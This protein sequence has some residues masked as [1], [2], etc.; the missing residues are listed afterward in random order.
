MKQSRQTLRRA[1]LKIKEKMVVQTE[2]KMI[3][4]AFLLAGDAVLV[5]DRR[6]AK[7]LLHRL[8]VTEYRVT[9]K[10]RKSKELIKCRSD[11]LWNRLFIVMAIMCG[12]NVYFNVNCVV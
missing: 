10:A 5:K 12:E 3:A 6:R 1:C 9:K 8:N 11:F 2:K 7:N 4:G